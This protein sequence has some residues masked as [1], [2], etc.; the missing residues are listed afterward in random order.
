[1]AVTFERTC[2]GCGATVVYTGHRRGERAAKDAW[3]REHGAH[4]PVAA[5]AV[6]AGA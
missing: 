5:S 6:K 2:A 4:G 1:M 3:E